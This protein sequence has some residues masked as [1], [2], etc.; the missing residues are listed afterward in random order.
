VAAPEKGAI[1]GT[2]G[3]FNWADLS[4]SDREAAVDFYGE[5]FGWEGD[6][7]PAGESG[8]YTLFRQGGKQ[9]AGGGEPPPDQPMPP[10]WTPYITVD[11]VDATAARVEGSGGTVMMPPM[12]VMGQGRMAIF[13]DP[14]GAVVAVWQDGNHTGA[15]VFD[16]H[17]AITWVE[18]G[19]G[20]VASATKFYNDVFGWSSQ[21]APDPQTGG[22]YTLFL[23]GEQ[24]VAGAFDK[25]PIMPDV[26]PHWLVYFMVDDAAA[27]AAK[28]KELGGTAGDEIMDVPGVGKISIINDPQGAVFGVLEPSAA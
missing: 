8:I 2:V 18:L 6:D 9:V 15:E 28:A 24:Q 10:A 12:D 23:I 3:K 7:Q 16:A 26:P 11:D 19:T 21:V 27:T 4:T 22:E 13:S 1:V 25:T 5:L 17:G 20:D 14:T